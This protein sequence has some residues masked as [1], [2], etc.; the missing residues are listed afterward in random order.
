MIKQQ[1]GQVALVLVLIMTVVGA[2]AVSLASRST[3]DTR[4]QENETKSVQALILAQTGLEQM[5]MNPMSTVINDA[6][7]TA[8]KTDEGM[9]SFTT[10][11]VYAGTT[12]EL[13]LEEAN[14]N[15]LTGFG[16]YWKRDVDTTSGNPAILISVTSNS[17]VITDYAYD[18]TGENGF[19]VASSGSSEGYEKR[20][21]KINLTNNVRKVRIMVLGAPA[22]MKIV[23]LETGALFPAQIK[24]VKAVGLVDSDGNSVKYGLQYDES[25][26]AAVPSVFDYA[27]FSSGS[28]IQ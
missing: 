27:L 8:N 2:L 28:I 3:V 14:F 6:T 22:L 11:L 26:V 7:Y 23:P 21:P 17:G 20:T 10:G 19:T 15:T 13:N 16:V 1:K 4:I 12:V 18:Y 25:A 5:M 24:S 9:T